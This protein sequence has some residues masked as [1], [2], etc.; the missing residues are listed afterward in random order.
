MKK[1]ISIISSILFLIPIPFLLHSAPDT[2]VEADVSPESIEGM[3]SWAMTSV[4]WADIPQ[5]AD[6]LIT[7]AKVDLG[8][9]LFFDPRL[10]GSNMMSCATCHHPKMGFSDGV[11]LFIGD[12]GNIGPRATPTAQNLAWNSS[13]FWDGRAGSLEEQAIMPIGSP[14][15]MNQEM[16]QLIDELFQAGYYPYFKKA[17]GQGAV[18]TPANIGKAIATYERTLVSVNSPFDRYMKGDKTALNSSQ[19]RGKE[20]FETKGQCTTCHFGP[21]FTDDGFH[22]IGIDTTD[23][24]RY[25]L[26][27]V[28]RMKYAFKTPGLRDV[29]FRAPYFHDGS[30]ATLEEVLELYDLGGVDYMRHLPNIAIQPLGLTELEKRDLVA[31]LEAL[32]GEGVYDYPVPRLP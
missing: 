30:A 12:H 17:F 28:E 23:A 18:M 21:N 29:A 20:V 31:F 5:P 3:A 22:N 16:R 25:K 24:G 26:V 9:M 15:E 6:N 14:E 2:P 32:T 19:L 1:L 7:E 4:Q 13:F 8:A 10:S 27:P 11:P